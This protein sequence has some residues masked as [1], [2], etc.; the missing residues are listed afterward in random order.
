MLRNDFACVAQL[1][2]Q[3]TCNEQVV[4]SNLTTGFKIKGL[5]MP[6]KNI[7]MSA[8][9]L[10][11]LRLHKSNFQYYMKIG[12]LSDVAYILR[13]AGIVEKTIEMKKGK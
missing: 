12:Q 2:E 5:T 1:V 4:S 11:Q 6:R 8:E 9:Q 10:E 3:F 13:L 7:N